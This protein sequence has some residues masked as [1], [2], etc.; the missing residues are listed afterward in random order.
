[1]LAPFPGGM[2]A[3]ARGVGKPEFHRV[4]CHALPVGTDS[5]LKWRKAEQGAGGSG[6][7][8]GVSHVFSGLKFGSYLKDNGH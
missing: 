3:T 7:R 5:H 1:M 6:Q 4:E 8:P 2:K